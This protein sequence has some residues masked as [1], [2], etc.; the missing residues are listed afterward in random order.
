MD[1]T[2]DT[3]TTAN[4]DTTTTKQITVVSTVN[5]I[6]FYT[7]NTISADYSAE[8]AG[9]LS[10]AATY[11]HEDNGLLVATAQELDNDTRIAARIIMLVQQT[12]P[13]IRCGVVSVTNTSTGITSTQVKMFITGDIVFSDNEVPRG[14]VI[15]KM[16][17]PLQPIVQP[18]K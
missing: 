14:F 6:V 1:M 8:L 12:Y 18:T 9:S 11:A 3:N 2:Q 16:Y 4:T 10:N 7:E 5:G 15:G 17:A 13:G